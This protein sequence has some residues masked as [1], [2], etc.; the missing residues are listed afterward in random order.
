[1]TAGEMT[2]RPPIR[3]AGPPTDS[4]LAPMPESPEGVASSLGRLELQLASQSEY[5]A[6]H[7]PLEPKA[8]EKVDSSV[9]MLGAIVLASIISKTEP[10]SLSPSDPRSVAQQAFDYFLESRQAPRQGD[11]AFA[12]RVKRDE[13]PPPPIISEV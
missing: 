11:R 8:P 10:L 3:A 12:V 2:E 1:M 9:E 7:G 13:A 6:P 5:V 4:R